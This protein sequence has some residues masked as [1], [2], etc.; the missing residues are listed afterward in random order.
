MVLRFNKL[1]NGQNSSRHLYMGTQKVG[2]EQEV[3]SGQFCTQNAHQLVE[4]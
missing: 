3:E 1:P 2:W 4:L